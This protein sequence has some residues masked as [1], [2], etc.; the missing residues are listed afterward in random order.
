[1]MENLAV[2]RARFGTGEVATS[3]RPET[4]EATAAPSR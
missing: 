1:V 3:G 2:Y 4:H